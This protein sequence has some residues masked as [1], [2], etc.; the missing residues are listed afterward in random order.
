MQASAPAECIAILATRSSILRV[1]CLFP[2]VI[3]PSF[4]I[5]EIAT[6][7]VSFYSLVA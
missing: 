4:D 7:N 5:S 6:R 2:R 3:A 1:F